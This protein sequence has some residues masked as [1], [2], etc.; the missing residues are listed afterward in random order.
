MWLDMDNLKALARAEERADMR[1]DERYDE[2]C[3][4][5]RRGRLS[6]DFGHGYEAK[7]NAE[8]TADN[9]RLKF[10]VNQLVS[11]LSRLNRRIEQLTEQ[12]N[13]AACLGEQECGASPVADAVSATGATNE[14]P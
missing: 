1:D 6:D 3:D 10:Q 5:K 11:K 7:R 13:A 9:A 8:L 2:A 12:P 4:A 14:V